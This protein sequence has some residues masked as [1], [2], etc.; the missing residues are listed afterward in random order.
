MSTALMVEEEKQNDDKKKNKFIGVVSLPNNISV[1][2][3]FDPNMY[4]Y[5]NVEKRT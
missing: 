1:E 3:T 5:Y 2:E 4:M